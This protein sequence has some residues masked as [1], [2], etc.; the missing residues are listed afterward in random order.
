LKKI[1]H[2]HAPF[3]SDAATVARLAARFAA[4]PYSFTPRAKDIFH[5]GVEMDDLRNKFRDAAG[6]I[7]LNDYQVPYLRNTFGPLAARVQRIY[8]GLDLQEFP[9]QAPDQRPPVIVAVGRLVPKKGFDDLIA[10]C[11]LLAG[12]R[13]QFHCRLIGAGP[14]TAE[15]RAQIDRLDLSSRV[16]LV[17]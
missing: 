6:V 5:K 4:V 10:A 1:H 8:N 17:G 3:A 7:T 14:L 16:E 12:R 11:A 2:L 15:L 13:R 9:F